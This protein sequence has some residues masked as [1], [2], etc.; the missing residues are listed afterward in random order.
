MYVRAYV[1]GE[2]NAYIVICIFGNKNKNEETVVDELFEKMCSFAEIS[3]KLNLR[4]K[5]HHG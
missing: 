3:K 2:S 1:S 5:T 4:Q